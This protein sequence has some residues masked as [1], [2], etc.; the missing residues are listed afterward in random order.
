[1]KQP[2]QQP[3][4]SLSIGD[5]VVWQDRPTRVLG[6]T[7]ETGI[8]IRLRLLVVEHHTAEAERAAER[9]EKPKDVSFWTGPI[10]SGLKV[11]RV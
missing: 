11:K 6:K 7:R 10:A 2:R 4:H 9:D 1:M 3:L 8:T 5:T